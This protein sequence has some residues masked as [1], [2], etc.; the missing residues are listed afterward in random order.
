MDYL[1]YRIRDDWETIAINILNMLK[2]I[3]TSTR[4][5]DISIPTS[6]K[7]IKP[8]ELEDLKMYKPIFRWLSLEISRLWVLT[9]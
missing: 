9:I 6:Q 1:F 5:L 8:I 4:F 2:S 7:T 3:Q